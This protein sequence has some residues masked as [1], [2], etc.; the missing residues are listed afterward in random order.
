MAGNIRLLRLSRER[1]GARAGDVLQ[2][3]PRGNRILRCVGLQAQQGRGHLAGAAVDGEA[4]DQ[5]G[6]SGGRGFVNGKHK[7]LEM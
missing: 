3:E 6:R 5:R 4:F 1:P 2:V 7:R